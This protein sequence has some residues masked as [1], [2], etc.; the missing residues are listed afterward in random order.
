MRLVC[1]EMLRF[2]AGSDELARLVAGGLG[3]LCALRTPR[4]QQHQGKRKS[5]KGA[6]M[7]FAAAHRILQQRKPLQISPSKTGNTKFF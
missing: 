1:R 4:L 5:G 3:T 6:A 7:A 2:V